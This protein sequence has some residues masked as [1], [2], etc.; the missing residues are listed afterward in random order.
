M[1]AA[2][3]ETAWR[4][5]DDA[6]TEALSWAVDDLRWLLIQTIASTT[7]RRAL[8]GSLQ[9]SAYQRV[10]DLGCGFGAA[11]LELAA[12]GD[13]VVVGVDTDPSALE[14][15]QR[16]GRAVTDRGGIPAGRAAFCHGDA[17]SIPFPDASFDVVFSRFV[18]Q[19]LDNPERAASEV[20]RILSPGGTACIVDV[21]DGLSISEPPP[22]AAFDRLASALRASQA[23]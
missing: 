4:S 11:A 15:A 22:S 19:H 8:I 2:V 20:A 17:Y 5:I 3:R 1:N 9:L 16:I 14:S 13:I 18:F 10:L 12:L 7:Q 6:L 21:D 23:A